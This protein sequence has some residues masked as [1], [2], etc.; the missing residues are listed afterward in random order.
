MMAKRFFAMAK[1][2]FLFFFAKRIYRADPTDQYYGV[3]Y[4]SV[5]RSVVLTLR[6]TDMRS[7]RTTLRLTDSEDE[8]ILR[9]RAGALRELVEG[10]YYYFRED[11]RERLVRQAWWKYHRE[12]SDPVAETIVNSFMSVIRK[13]S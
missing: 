4:Q 13:V 7:V 3:Y 8:D 2:F 12:S 1:R 10:E 9:G 6:L 11:E 5:L